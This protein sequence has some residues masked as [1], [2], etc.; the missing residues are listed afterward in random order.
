MQWIPVT[1]ELL[2]GGVGY[3]LGTMRAALRSLNERHPHAA[4]DLARGAMHDFRLAHADRLGPAGI[5]AIAALLERELAKLGGNDDCAPV[6]ASDILAR[7]G[8]TP[9]PPPSGH[10]PI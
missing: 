2:M 1:A 3:G 10:L 6:A 8:K 5:D 4:A 7:T 9:R